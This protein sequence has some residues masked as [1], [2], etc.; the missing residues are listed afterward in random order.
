MRREA[1][2]AEGGRKKRTLPMP[3]PVGSLRKTLYGVVL[4][5]LLPT[6]GV[7]L[8]L[9]MDTREKAMLAAQKKSMEAVRDIAGQKQ[10]LLENTRILLS[11]I[12]QLESVRALDE[13][14]ISALFQD[15]L[16]R[17]P[18]YRNFL[19]ADPTG[20]VR[21]AG[22]A[23][24]ATP[25]AGRLSAAGWPE[26]KKALAG[27]IFVLDTSRPK[28]NTSTPSLYFAHPVRADNGDIAGVLL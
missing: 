2:Y 19:L 9:N 24:A 3:L 21:A 17:Y 22:V 12:A 4:M 15:I 13:G 6:F 10:L 18:Q 1:A 28:G 27:E 26:F 16:T 23:G 7:T 8:Y 20:A 5:A 11:G 25:A 14:R